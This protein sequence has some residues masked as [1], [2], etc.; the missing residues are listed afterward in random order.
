MRDKAIELG[1]A[2]T[3][4]LCQYPQNGYVPTNAES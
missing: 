3:I 1:D 4:V 2:V